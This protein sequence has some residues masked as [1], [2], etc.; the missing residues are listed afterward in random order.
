MKEDPGFTGNDLVYTEAMFTVG[1]IIFPDT[2]YSL[3]VTVNYV[4]PTLEPFRSSF[5]VGACRVSSSS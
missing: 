4:L 5:T 3:K 2:I 1:S